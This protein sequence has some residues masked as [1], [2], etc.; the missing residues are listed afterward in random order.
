[1]FIGS[2]YCP[3]NNDKVENF[4]EMIQLAEELGMAPMTTFSSCII[5]KEFVN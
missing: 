2:V 4:D 1:M 3:Q 5:N